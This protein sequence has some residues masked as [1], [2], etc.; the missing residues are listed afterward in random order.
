MELLRRLSAERR[1]SITSSQTQ[2][3][4][5]AQEFGD[6]IP[7][8][9]Q[10]HMSRNQQFRRLHYL[11]LEVSS[12]IPMGGQDVTRIRDV[13]PPRNIRVAPA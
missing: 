1:H 8:L 6:L 3:I 10:L 7:E 5:G 12:Q 9:D 2:R 4:H 13:I 11:N